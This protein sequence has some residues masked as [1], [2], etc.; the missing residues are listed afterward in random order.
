MFFFTERM[1]GNLKEEIKMENI[2][3]KEEIQEIIL[4]SPTVEDTCA[5]YIK[6]EEIKMEN[7]GIQGKLFK[8]NV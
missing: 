4:P 6:E 3:I 5:V 2:E 7:T 1:A 8:I